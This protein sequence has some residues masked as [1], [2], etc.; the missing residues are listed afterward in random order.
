MD[1]ASDIPSEIKYLYTI[2]IMSYVTNMKIYAITK[3]I[4]DTETMM[5]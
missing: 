4:L 5:Y 1:K 2:V 3:N